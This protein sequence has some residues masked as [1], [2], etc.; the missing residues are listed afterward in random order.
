MT[1]VR[2]PPLSIAL[3]AIVITAIFAPVT[4]SMVGNGGDYLLHMHYAQL[5][6]QDGMWGKPVPHF[7]YQSL[8]LFF[9]GLLPGR[10][11]VLA[12]AVVNMFS[13]MAVGIT[14]FILLYRL[15]GDF[16][17]RR[18]LV[19]ASVFTA[20]LML[21]EPITLFTLHSQN[22]YF[23]YIAVQSYHSPTVILLRPL[24]LWLFLFAVRVFREPKASVPL[25]LLCA[26]VAMLVSITKP[27]YGIAIL[28]ALALVTLYALYR[29][30]PVD[31][32][33]LLVGIV[34]PI[35][36]VIIWQYFFYRNQG[37]GGFNIAPFQVMGFYS[38]APGSLPLKFALSIVFPVCVLALYFKTAIQDTA[39]RLAWIAFLF[40]IFYVYFMVDSLVWQAGNFLWSGE[41]TLLILFIASA[42]FLLRQ[43]M[44][45]RTWTPRLLICA[46]A[47]SLHLVSGILFYIP[48]LT[49]AW[50]SSY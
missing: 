23:G 19:G 41:I 33:L 10:S 44:A 21:V 2:V 46:G 45:T 29:R 48:H 28:P 7:L 15:L 4:V 27:N 17:P 39:L 42:F 16:R 3:L 50:N 13:Y 47:L 5:W 32:R 26:L 38:P 11:L 25:V 20:I 40:G 22:M 1:S 49:S 35:S 12:A 6:E 30:K 18:R 34:I 37:I 36:E 24:A 31:W 9:K 43:Y 8:L 14:L